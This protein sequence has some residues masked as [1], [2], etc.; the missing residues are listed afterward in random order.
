ME[1][2]R[3]EI[4]GTGK[5]ALLSPTPS[6]EPLAHIAKTDPFFSQ[7]AAWGDTAYQLWLHV[8]DVPGAAPILMA[9]ATFALDTCGGKPSGAAC[10][11]G[12]PCTT[13]DT[14]ASGTCA[15]TSAT[16]CDDINSCTDD[17]CDPARGCVHAFNVGPCDDGDACTV[18]RPAP[19]ASASR[20]AR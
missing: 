5:T 12:N 19:S 16:S 17:S 14:C 3:D 8:K 13:G 6:G 7:L 18:E 2:L 10:D 9:Q 11:D 20:T 4:N 1:F 15:G